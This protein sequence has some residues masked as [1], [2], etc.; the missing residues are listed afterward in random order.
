MKQKRF[1]VNGSTSLN[2]VQYYQ[3]K[4]KYDLLSCVKLAGKNQENEI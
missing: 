1:K 4:T 2:L 3:I